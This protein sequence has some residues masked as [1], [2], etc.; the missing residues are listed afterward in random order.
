[1]EEGSRLLV[2]GLSS[3]EVTWPPVR[4]A[5]HWGVGRRRG[6]CGTGRLEG[7]SRRCTMQRGTKSGGGVLAGGHDRQQARRAEEAGAS[8]EIHC[9]RVGSGQAPWT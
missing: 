7:Q 9:L 3:W 8:S 4:P 2:L 6:R 5:G 1:M